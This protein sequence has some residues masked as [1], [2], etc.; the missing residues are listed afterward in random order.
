[1]ISTQQELISQIECMREKL[2]SRAVA[3]CNFCKDSQTLELSHGLDKL[4]YQ[5]MVTYAEA[6]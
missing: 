6:P 2:N 5:Y 3:D 1:M 4:I